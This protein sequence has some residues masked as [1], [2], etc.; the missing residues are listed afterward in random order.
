MTMTS[1]NRP[2]TLAAAIDAL[3]AERGQPDDLIRSLRTAATRITRATARS[4]NDI[5]LAPRDVRPLLRAVR[6]AAIGGT[7]KACTNSLSALRQLGALTGWTSGEP[8]LAGELGEAWA[9]LVARLP[10][11]PKRSVLR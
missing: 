1:N 7:R 8:D 2:T 3:L 10:V 11:S 6:P 5:P 4:A 9:A